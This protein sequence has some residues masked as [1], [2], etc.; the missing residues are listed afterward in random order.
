MANTLR[1][2]NRS[3]MH[4]FGISRICYCFYSILTEVLFFWKYLGYVFPIARLMSQNQFWHH[5]SSILTF[6][7]HLIFFS[8]LLFYLLYI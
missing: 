2:N 5:S 1:L 3:A 8:Y 7:K 6:V 4:I